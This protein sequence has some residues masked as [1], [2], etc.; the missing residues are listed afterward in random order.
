MTLP[1][2]KTRKVTSADAQEIQALA[3]AAEM[4]SVEE[5]EFLGA[6]LKDDRIPRHDGIAAKLG[7]LPVPP[8]RQGP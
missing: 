6:M 1:Q 4:F 3:V 7:R 2:Y 5:A 8:S